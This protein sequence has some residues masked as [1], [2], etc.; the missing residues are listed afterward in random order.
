MKQALSY[1]LRREYALRNFIGEHPNFLELVDRLRKISDKPVTVL[2]E[3][4]TGTGKSYCAE[5]I[6]LYSDRHDK[7]FISYNCGSGPDNLFESQLFGHAKG[8]FTGAIRDKAGLVEEAHTG[9][10]FL[11]EINSLDFA[12]QVKLNHFLETGTFRRVGETRQRRVDVRVIAASLVDLRQAIAQKAFRE[13]LYYRLAEYS[14]KV[15]PLRQRKA[16]ILALAR[17][18]LAKNAKLN[19]MEEMKLSRRAED[20]LLNYSWPGNIRELENCIKR[21]LIDT[22]SNTIDRLDLPCEDVPPF[23]LPGF[24]N[25][26]NLPWKEAKK[27]V[28]NCFE[29]NYLTALLK[30]HRGVVAQCARQAQMQ[31]PDFW[32]LMRKHGIK[33]NVFR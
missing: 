15:P 31:P 25:L 8:A 29:K 20:S 5:F 3:G 32:K 2:L 30:K 24:P 21:C 12:S 11:D 19:G 26:E 22:T 13:D 7:P 23:H 1:S 14:L 28:I 10:L 33:A 16:D 17:Y 9:T 4:E 27:H 18:F 6:H